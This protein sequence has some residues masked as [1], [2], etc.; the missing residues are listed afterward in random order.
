MLNA[1]E[2]EHIEVDELEFDP[3]KEDIKDHAIMY[4]KQYKIL[5]SNLN[6]IR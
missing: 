4:G 5:N 1:E 6:T 3:T 2:D